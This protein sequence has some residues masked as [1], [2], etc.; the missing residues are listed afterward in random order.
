MRS[1]GESMQ[2]SDEIIKLLEYL[3]EKIGITIDWT[4]DNVFPYLQQLC[5]HFIKWEVGTSIGWI[6][7][8]I[9]AVIA[10]LVFVKFADMDGFELVIFWLIV[11][12]AIVVIGVQV[13]DIIEC[14]TF[15]E[16]VIHDYILS[17]MQNSR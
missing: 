5:E 7:M 12:A 6:V 10:G 1:R 13:F 16:K 4:S 3:C 8:A 11:V 2:L 17:Y 9:V 14:Y 15:P